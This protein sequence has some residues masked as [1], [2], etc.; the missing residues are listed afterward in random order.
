VAA[1]LPAYEGDEPYVFVSYS[2]RDEALVYRE[3]RWLQEQGVKVWY[4]IQ[5]QAGSEWSDALANAI[6]GCSRFLYFI[7]PNSVASE[8]CRRELNY[9]IAEHRSILAVHLQQTEV[10]GGIRLSLDNRQAI[11]K[12]RLTPGGYRSTILRALTT[13]G[14]GRESERAADSSSSWRIWLVSGAAAMLLLAIS[15][16]W[17]FQRTPEQRGKAPNLLDRSIAVLPLTVVGSDDP[18]ATNLAQALTE[19]VRATIA[20]YGE[21]RS[22]AQLDQTGFLELDTSYVLRGSVQ[23]SGEDLRIRVGLIRSDDLELC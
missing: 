17:L 1:P 3:I 20:G 4:D 22:V 16:I 2:H 9:A 8:N 7:T 13:D 15:T 10:P 5:I 23:R 21:L 11:L 6:A 12:H 18:A 14:A 19:E